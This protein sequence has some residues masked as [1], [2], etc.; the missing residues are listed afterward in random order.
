MYKRA[1]SDTVHSCHS[2]Q[3]WPPDPP[4]FQPE[5]DAVDQD[6]G[7]AVSSYGDEGE[8][9]K[10]LRCEDYYRR[11]DPQAGRGPSG[12]GR[13]NG[14]SN[15]DV[16]LFEAVVGASADSEFLFSVGLLDLPR[17][18]KKWVKYLTGLSQ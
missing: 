15:E 1:Q 2:E 10:E 16:L 3:Y 12:G 6:R 8:R 17:G 4:R 13:G 14:R 18:I 7:P 11:D 5:H 9:A